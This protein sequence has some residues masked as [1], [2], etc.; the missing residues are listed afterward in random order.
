MSNFKCCL[1]FYYKESCL[2]KSY[3][4]YYYEYRGIVNEILQT[5]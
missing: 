2:N 5:C 4:P 3:I 1:L